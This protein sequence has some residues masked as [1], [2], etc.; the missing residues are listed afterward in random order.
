M[1]FTDESASAA[2]THQVPSVGLFQTRPSA[3]ACCSARQSPRSGA[4]CSA[5]TPASSPG[6]CYSWAGLPRP[7]L[8][9]QGTADRHLA[10]RSGR[11]RS[12][13]GTDRRQGRRSA[14]RL[15]HRRVV[16]GRR[17]ARCPLADLRRPRRGADRHRPAVGSAS[18]VVPLY[19]GEVAPP[20]IRGGLVG[21]NQLAITGGILISYLVDYGLANSQKLATHVRPS[22][23]TGDPDVHGDPLPAREPAL[24]G[25]PRPRGRG[26]RGAAPGPRRS[27][28]RGRDRRG[29]RAVGP[30]IERARVA[31]PGSPPRDGHRR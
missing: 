23:D 19:I 26:A 1:K 15:G 10:D 28:H 24:A 3:A 13:G 5:T 4:C 16:R 17:A 18:M 11:R 6:H 8:V 14:H 27:W 30:L 12:A 9:R 29:A 20:R 21:F 7:D 31:Q 25:G 2:R 22:R